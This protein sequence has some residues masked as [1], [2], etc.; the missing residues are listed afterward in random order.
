M[1]KNLSFRDLDIPA[2]QLS[3]ATLSIKAGSYITSIK[4]ILEQVSSDTEESKTK[5]LLS[6]IWADEAK[7]V[8]ILIREILLRLL[9]L[10]YLE[11]EGLKS[12]QEASLYK[13]QSANI[14]GEA[15]RALLSSFEEKLNGKG[16]IDIKWKHQTPPN[17]VVI[18]H[19]EILENQIKKIQRN[20]HK[21]DKI[22]SSFEDYRN[23]Y[24]D[25][26]DK[27]IQYVD[28]IHHENL[29]L[30]KSM[31]EASIE[32]D[33]SAVIKLISKVDQAVDHLD[34]LPT[35]PSYDNVILEDIDKLQLPVSSDD[36]RLQYKNIDILSEVS[37]WSSF[38]L[39]TPLKKIDRQIV[40]YKE[41]TNVIL[42]QLS[43]RLKAKIESTTGDIITFVPKEHSR[44]LNKIIQ[45]YDT[46]LKPEVIDS[47]G[48]IKTEVL[49]QLEIN[50]LFD[51]NESFL[52]NSIRGQLHTHLT[53]NKNL[54][55]RY[56]LQNIKDAFHQVTSGHFLKDE[57]ANKLSAAAYV[58][59]VT[60]FDAES[61]N[62][63]LFMRKGF[64]GTSFTVNRTQ[65]L[66]SID[67]H[68]A[69]WKEGYGGG[70][71]VKGEPGSGRSNILEIL[72]IR[73]NQIPSHHIVIGL[74]LVVKGYKHLVDNDLIKTLQFIIKNKGNDPCIVT[75]D[76]L[77]QFKEKAEDHLELMREVLSI[78]RKQSTKIYF[79]LTLTNDQYHS[80][81]NIFDLDNVFTLVVATDHMS[82]TKIAEAISMRAFAVAYQEELETAN[83]VAIDER[84]KKIAK[85]SN[86][87]IGLAM[88][89]WCSNTIINE[90]QET[91]FREKIMHHA[92]LLN[93]ILRR[94]KIFIPHLRDMYDSAQYSLLIEDVQHL[95]DIKI[96]L[97][98]KDG[99]L[100]V[101]PALRIRISQILK[102]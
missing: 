56:E 50:K 60:N 101:N 57:K 74:P 96:L 3:I 9:Q 27:R 26:L 13:R 15:S 75:I 84:A 77:T 1:I 63:V 2:E 12:E 20:E 31:S 34:N 86:G 28:G 62:N 37:T 59:S 51:I 100:K 92:V 53:F 55:N 21:L 49:P 79:A 5:N 44:S 47:I 46:L 18:E 8:V 91:L 80:L 43:N 61:D 6:Y 95:T 73:Y 24:I 65:I 81:T 23:S 14:L 35:L 102:D 7:E 11:K 16:E 17:A 40:N 89:Q 72:P 54:A 87:N 36:G 88:Q 4:E 48:N 32:S 82:D 45:E 78:I 99:Y 83:V 93:Y 71:L 22:K 85:S 29:M 69:L 64:L 98:L 70:L 30:S 76:D 33:R 58:A 10:K 67:R 94:E 39:L 38:N 19:L 25:Y 52:P 90:A 41:K 42:F 97:R 68:F 66:D